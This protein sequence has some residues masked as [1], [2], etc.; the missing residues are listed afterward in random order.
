MSNTP[1]KKSQIV[2]FEDEPL[3]LV[4][5][6]DQVT[7]VLDKAGCHD[8][9]GRLHRAFSLFIFNANG[10]LLM[11][12]RAQGKRL[13]PGFWS[14]SCC[15]HPRNGED[16]DAAA[17]RR[18]WEELSQRAELSFVYKFEYK[19]SYEDRGTEHELC[20]VYVGR[21]ND[22]PVVNQ[23]EV[24]EIRWISAAELNAEMAASPG[25]FTPWFKLEWRALTQHHA[26][27]LPSVS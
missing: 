5:S 18:L 10:E 2:S 20:W 21:S 3:M 17:E 13:W 4:D 16:T 19:A 14:N 12:K 22:E 26:A 24:E 8:G 11:Q 1:Q 15:S 27:L 7:G 6:D 23:E 25:A 9:D